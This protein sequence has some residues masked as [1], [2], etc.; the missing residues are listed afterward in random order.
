IGLYHAELGCRRLEPLLQSLE[1]QQASGEFAL[2]RPDLLVRCCEARNDIPILALER[3]Q[4][5]AKH[6]SF[7]RNLVGNYALLRDVLDALAVVKF[8]VD[9]EVVA[10]HYLVRRCCFVDALER[11]AKRLVV[12][13]LREGNEQVRGLRIDDHVVE[14]IRFPRNE[15]GRLPSW[16]D[17]DAEQLVGIVARETFEKIR[18]I[19]EEAVLYLGRGRHRMKHESPRLG[20]VMHD[21]EKILLVEQ[22]LRRAVI[23]DEVVFS[24]MLGWACVEV[25]IKPD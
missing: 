14:D 19:V 9:D 18:L 1:S 15:T 20:Q 22:M 2:Q 10:R 11:N 16:P 4:F 23:G 13:L 7:L 12:H 6:E 21:L 17:P 24:D 3:R 5:V 8:A 25:E